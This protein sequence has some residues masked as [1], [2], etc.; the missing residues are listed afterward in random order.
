[1]IISTAAPGAVKALATVLALVP[2][3]REITQK[4]EAIAPCIQVSVYFVRYGSCS[5]KNAW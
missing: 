3:F 1:M 4:R 2:T 5:P